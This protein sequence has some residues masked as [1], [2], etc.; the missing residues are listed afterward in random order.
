MLKTWWGA[1]VIFKG[2]REQIRHILDMAGVIELLVYGYRLNLE[3]ETNFSH[4]NFLHFL[5]VHAA[6]TR[7]CALSN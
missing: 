7:K 1:R 4:L 6:A 2:C 5:L 3:S